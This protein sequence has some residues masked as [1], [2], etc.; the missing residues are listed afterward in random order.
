MEV[1]V[2]ALMVITLRDIY[3]PVMFN[4]TYTWYVNVTD[5]VTDESFNS[6]TF[7]F[8]TADPVDCPCGEEELRSVTGRGEIVD[9]P[10][11]ELVVFMLCLGC[12]VLLRK[13]FL[14]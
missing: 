4:T 12:I 11:F 14:L 10:G 7:F 9:S 5:T 6:D 1:F 13:R 8:T 2:F 3:H